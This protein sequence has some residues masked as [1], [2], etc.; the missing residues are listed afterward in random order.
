MLVLSLVIT[1]R[2]TALATLERK[3]YLTSVGISVPL[4]G[5]YGHRYV[6]TKKRH[7]LRTIRRFGMSI[8]LV[9]YIRLPNE[10]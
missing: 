8:V 4:F 1:I 5:V 7:K 3:P 6:A 10:K 2:V 9:S